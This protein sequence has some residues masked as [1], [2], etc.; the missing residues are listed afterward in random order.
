MGLRLTTSVIALT[1]F[2]TAFP[3]PARAQEAGPGAAGPDLA[4]AEI[5]V[6]ANKRAQSLQ[7]T[8]VAV[9]AISDEQ[10]RALN[11]VTVTD[12]GAVAPSINFAEAPSPTSSSFIIRGIG[13]FAFN[14]ALEQ[15]VGI[16]I[17]GVPQARL[18]GSIADAVDVGQIQVLR[19]PQ[20]TIF[21]KNATAGVIDIAYRDAEFETGVEGRLFYGSDD[22]ARAQ[23]TVN[24][25]MSDRAAVRLTGWYFRR[26]GWIRAPL[27]P[28]GDIG[29]FER[30]GGRIKLALLPADGW[31]IDLTG[32]WKRDKDDGS[33]QTLRGYLPT[34]RDQQIREMEE[35]VG[36]FAGPKNR[37][38]L[39]DFPERNSAEQK[40]LVLK[41][42]W[43]VGSNSI[44]AIIGYND[45]D[46]DGIWD[47]DFT[48][49]R[50]FAQGSIINNLQRLKQFTAELRFA[51]EGTGPLQYTAGLF[52]Y[53]FDSVTHFDAQNLIIAAPPSALTSTDLLNDLHTTNHA[54][55]ADLS[56]RF[57]KVTLLAGGRLSW[58]KTKGIFD[59]GPS[60]Q[61]VTPNVLFGPFHLENEVTYD[62]FS[63]R[64]G[65]Q[66]E[67]VD[68]VMVYGTASRAYKGPGFNYTF[69][70][71][72]ALVAANGGYI[73]AEIG[74]SY[75]LGVRSRLFDRQLTLNLTG[76]YSPFT[77]FQVTSVIP[78]VPPTF[79]TTN[80]PE[81]T[82][83]GIELEFAVNPRAL[84]GFTAFG[85]LV[86]NDTRY[87]DFRTAPCFIGQ[88][89]VAEPTDAV[90]VCAPFAPGSA[91]FV[92]NVTGLKTVGVPRWQANV[93]ARYEAPVS[94]RLT[95]FG[96]VNYAFHDDIQYSV[97]RPEE[98]IQPAYSLVHLT[99]GIGDAGDRWRFSAY[100]RNLFDQH[101]VGRIAFAN[102]GITQSLSHL[103][104]RTVGASLDLRF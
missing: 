27:Q 79:S 104:S 36:Q 85:S 43:D 1:A 7:D 94:D 100:V 18:I 26:G 24:L 66:W 61:F 34:P 68:D 72:A 2:H 76:F 21:G 48:D 39:K 50:T 41:S 88:P 75:E 81:V 62:D 80:A 77:N 11:V 15:S 40:R 35:A 31:R 93:T 10:L 86:Y 9:T 52:L 45:T 14:D 101:F 44:T 42:V 5:I 33:L 38:T 69:T 102:P 6:T 3:A 56:Y 73:D 70:L 47:S 103:S 90:G 95:A 97:G 20:G 25:P 91:L 60:Q 63:W 32:E 37:S 46:F 78:T 19:G 29:E 55:F 64:A 87:T 51:S 17:D 53:D 84:R 58:E 12:I 99:A 67:P 83:K 4:A 54:A 98:T 30:Y 96:Q 23:A 65:F 13:T 92:Q 28:D 22:E 89:Q 74:K 57:G 49:S 71:N 59:R 8:P 16:V 82:A